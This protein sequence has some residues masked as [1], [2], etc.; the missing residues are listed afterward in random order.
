MKK[1]TIG[2]WIVVAS[3]VIVMLMI[4]ACQSSPD[5][6]DS[7]GQDSDLPGVIIPGDPT[8]ESGDSDNSTDSGSGEDPVALAQQE[9]QS[10][11]HASSFVFDSE[12]INNPCARCHSPKDWMPTLDDIPESC[13]ACKFELEPPPPFIAESDWEHV[14]CVMCHQVDKKGNVDPEVS[15]LEIPPLDE[16][17]SVE[18]PSELCLKCHDT[19]GYA[20]HGQV[21]VG[22]G[23]ADMQ[24]TECHSPHATTATCVTGDCHAGVLSEADQIP[25]HDEDHEDVSCAACHDNAGW[26]VGPHPETGIWVTFSPWSHVVKVG[27]EDSIQ[28][29]GTIPF[30]SHDLGLE[31]NC[32]RCHFSGNTWGLTESV[33]KP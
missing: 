3:L 8:Q 26:D 2:H 29:I 25:G 18:T 16:Y 11:S 5:Q 13:Q 20:E 1:K 33:E 6:P 28:Q 24:C 7:T 4:T 17:V 30:S 22:S 10:S 14:S 31:V 32:E 9:W 27:E 15:W 12:G 21:L 23:H 19:E